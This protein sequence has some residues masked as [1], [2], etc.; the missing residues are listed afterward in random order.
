MG[1]SSSP[2]VPPVAVETA[3]AM[4]GDMGMGGCG[5]PTKLLPPVPACGLRAGICTA[6]RAAYADMKRSMVLGTGVCDASEL[7]GNGFPSLTNDGEKAGTNG[8]IDSLDLAALTAATS[9]HTGSMGG[10]GG[11]KGGSLE[12]SNDDEKTYGGKAGGDEEIMPVTKGGCDPC[13]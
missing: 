6:D 7:V 13:I 9:V 1:G 4:C 2:V 3:M 12:C 10:G 5:P 8:G 11:G